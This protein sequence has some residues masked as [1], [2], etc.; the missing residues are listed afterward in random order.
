[1]SPTHLP[2]GK[3]PGGE[4]GTAET[5]TAGTVAVT[6][7]G[8]PGAGLLGRRIPGLQFKL[9]LQDVETALILQIRAGSWGWERKSP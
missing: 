2:G 4:Q 5:W 3:D 9:H 6:A 1:M 7:L 8:F